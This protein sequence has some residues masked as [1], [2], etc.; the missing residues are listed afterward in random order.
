MGAMILCAETVSYGTDHFQVEYPPRE[1]LQAVL[2]NK[3]DAPPLVMHPIPAKVKCFKCG[4]SNGLFL[5]RC[6]NCARA[7]F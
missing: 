2:F 3:D 4:S 5:F 1:A 7:L 6:Y